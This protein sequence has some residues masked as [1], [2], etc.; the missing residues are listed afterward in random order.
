MPR[1]WGLGCACARVR[2]CRQQ[3][4]G[5]LNYGSLSNARANVPT[6]PLNRAPTTD[7]WNYSGRRDD[8]KLYQRLQCRNSVVARAKPQRP[9]KPL[10]PVDARSSRSI[11]SA[12]TPTVAA[13]LGRHI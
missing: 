11:S 5:L 10:G 3:T 4:T 8:P 12:N 2:R 1:K 13:I 6:Y 7:R 9:P